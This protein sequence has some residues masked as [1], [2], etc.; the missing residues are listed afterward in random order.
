MVVD[1]C[2]DVVAFVLPGLGICKRPPAAGG[3]S[4]GLTFDVVPGHPELS[5]LACRVAS[6]DPAVKMPELPQQLVHAEGLD[7]L[8]DWISNLPAASC[9]P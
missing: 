2:G 6:S 9:T 3:G 7:L 1:V 5:V 4:C 8:R